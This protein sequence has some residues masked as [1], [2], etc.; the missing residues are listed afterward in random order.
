MHSDVRCEEEVQS[1]NTAAKIAGRCFTVKIAGRC[2]IVNKAGTYFT[3][4]FQQTLL[5]FL[6][7]VRW[8]NNALNRE[9][10]IF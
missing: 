4:R 10:Y 6:N 9:L 7:I 3:A 2:F 8:D 5:T 1:H